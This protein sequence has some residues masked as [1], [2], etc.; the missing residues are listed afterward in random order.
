MCKAKLNKP[1]C[2]SLLWK[3]FRGVHK[4]KQ[5]YVLNVCLKKVLVDRVTDYYFPE[6]TNDDQLQ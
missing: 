3:P 2:I 1:P 4:Q 5:T 6:R